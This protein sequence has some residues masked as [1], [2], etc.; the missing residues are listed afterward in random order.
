MAWLLSILG[1][2]GGFFKAVPDLIRQWFY[3]QAKSAGRS[4]A[5][6]E[7]ARQEIE[8]AKRSGEIVAENRDPEST[9]DR[10]RDGS[11]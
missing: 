1:A 7:Q 3:R 11:F 2:V 4:E 10:L 9:A 8:N 6:L 5:E